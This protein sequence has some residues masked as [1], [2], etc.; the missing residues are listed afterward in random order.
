VTFVTS[1]DFFFTS[2]NEDNGDV[3]LL[4]QHATRLRHF[5]SFVARLAAP[6]FFDIS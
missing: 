4:I 2:V 5:V 6:H 1:V 3:A